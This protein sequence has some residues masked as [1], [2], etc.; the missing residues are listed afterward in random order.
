M[1]LCLIIYS[2]HLSWVIDLIFTW[3][4]NEYN[5]VMMMEITLECEQIFTVSTLPPC[6]F[7]MSDTPSSLLC[8]LDLSY[9]LCRCCLWGKQCI[10]IYFIVSPK[11][12]FKTVIRNCTHTWDSTRKVL[13]RGALAARF[14]LM[15]CCSMWALGA[16]HPHLGNVLQGLRS[17]R[18][19]LK[20]MRTT[21]FNIYTK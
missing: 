2:S 12:T 9:T 16:A 6:S 14:G 21:G 17:P 11:I 1:G 8:L 20:M 4:E 18:S 3:F 13:T 5:R 15:A 7:M 19:S 10:M